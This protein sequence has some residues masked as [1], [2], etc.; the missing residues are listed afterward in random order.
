MR[1]STLLLPPQVLDLWTLHCLPQSVAQCHDTAYLAGVFGSSSFVGAPCELALGHQILQPTARRRPGAT[2]FRALRRSQ[3][4]E[5]SWRF[6]FGMGPDMCAHII[7]NLHATRSHAKHA[8]E[9][10]LCLASPPV[11]FHHA[12][13]CTGQS[14]R[15]AREPRLFCVLAQR[16]CRS[17]A[18][19]SSCPDVLLLS[20][21]RS[22][23]G[24]NPSRSTPGTWAH[25]G[26]AH[27]FVTTPLSARTLWSWQRHPS[28]P[29]ATV[30]A[31]LWIPSPGSVVAAPCGAGSRTCPVSLVCSQSLD[32]GLARWWGWVRGHD[33]GPGGR[34][35]RQRL[36]MQHW[37]C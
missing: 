15:P 3:P 21:W 23:S 36:R 8:S 29:C 34:V 17:L 13:P 6:S 37:P 9:A 24:P 5:K 16:A 4:P 19:A 30:V 7:F 1:R 10:I 31:S 35:A 20:Y 28:K 11:G 32:L 27:R 2:D 22:P 25:I 26:V 18:C 12:H 33:P 14:S